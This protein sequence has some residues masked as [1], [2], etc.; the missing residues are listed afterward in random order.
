VFFSKVIRRAA[1]AMILLAPL[2]AA[3]TGDPPSAFQHEEPFSNPL[4]DPGLRGGVNVPP[5]EG[6]PAAAGNAGT[7]LSNTVAEALRNAEIAASEGPAIN[8]RFAL[9]GKFDPSAGKP[10]H[11]AVAWTLVDDKGKDV[12]HFVTQQPGDANGLWMKTTATDAVTAM[13]R[14]IVDSEGLP[15]PPEEMP[16]LTIAGIDG[17]PG[18]GGRALASS[19]EY[20]L[21]Q[22][23]LTISDSVADH[24]ALILGQVSLTPSKLPAQDTLTLAWTVLRPNGSEIGTIRQANNVPKGTLDQPWGDLAFIIAQGAA[25]GIVDLLRKTAGKPQA[26]AENSAVAAQAGVAPP[27]R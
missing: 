26:N 3:C 23:G 27:S 5:V 9:L 8:G 11:I 24:G 10:G 14:Y 21:K 15:P 22:A 7:D 12:R 13:N 4:L 2:L 17:A 1:A 20:H 25:E 19:L 6:F 16:T 18:A